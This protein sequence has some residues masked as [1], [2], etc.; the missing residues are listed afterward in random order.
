[1]GHISHSYADGA[2][3]YFLVLYPLTDDA[4]GQWLAIKRAPLTPS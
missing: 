3:V 1:M 4:L 2:C